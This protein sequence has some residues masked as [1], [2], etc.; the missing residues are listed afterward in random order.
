MD[1]RR[2]CLLTI[3]AQKA[4][5]SKKVAGTDFL[6]FAQLNN[7]F[8]NNEDKNIGVPKKISTMPFFRSSPSL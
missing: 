7:L 5:P 3:L 1:E 4:E 8:Q 6:L 2:E